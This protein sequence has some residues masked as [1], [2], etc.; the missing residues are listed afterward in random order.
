MGQ[1]IRFDLWDAEN[2]FNQFKRIFDLSFDA[3]ANDDYYQTLSGQL[4][5]NYSDDDKADLENLI[6]HL[7]LEEDIQVAQA[8]LGS[9]LMSNYSL[10]EFSALEMCRHFLFEKGFGLGLRDLGGQGVEK[11]RVISKLTSHGLPI[12]GQEWEKVRDYRD[13][14]NIIAHKHGFLDSG[15]IAKIEKAIERNIGLIALDSS[16]G[17]A[18]TLFIGRAYVDESFG[19]FIRYL[20]KLNRCFE[21]ELSQC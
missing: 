12:D 4:A 6:H 1:Q 21:S 10:F 8:F 7:K 9:V 5:E 2:R 15:S 17:T 19:C 16:S 20:R 18:T 13:I 3:I 14:R 11:I